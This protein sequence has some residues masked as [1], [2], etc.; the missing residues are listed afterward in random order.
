MLL[1]RRQA[2]KRLKSATGYSVAKC[3]EV[4]K[5]LPAVIDGARSKVYLTHLEAAIRKANEPPETKETKVVF[6]QSTID[7][8]RARCL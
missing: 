6:R 8:I 4:I 5:S 7:K 1:T 3:S 2:R